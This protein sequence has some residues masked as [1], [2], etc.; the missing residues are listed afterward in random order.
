MILAQFPLSTQDL[1][2][3]TLI[4]KDAPEIGWLMSLC[5]HQVLEHVRWGKSFGMQLETLFLVL[6]NQERNQLEQLGLGVRNIL[7]PGP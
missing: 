1:G 6:L 4:C 5:F 3:G 7:P 2:H